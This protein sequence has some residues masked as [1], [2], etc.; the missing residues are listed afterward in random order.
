MTTTTTTA[1]LAASLGV[2]AVVVF[3]DGEALLTIDLP[4]L[5]G[6]P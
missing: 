6:S 5:D 4:K 3:E 2:R 1:E